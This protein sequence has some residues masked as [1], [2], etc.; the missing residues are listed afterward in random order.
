MGVD[1]LVKTRDPA[2]VGALEALYADMP[3][4]LQWVVPRAL[5]RTN[6][7]EAVEA[8]GRMYQASQDEGSRRWLLQYLARSEG[9]EANRTLWSILERATEPSQRAEAW[10]ALASRPENADLALAELRSP[11]LESSIRRTII[12]SLRGS[13]DAETQELLWGV[14]GTAT[15]VVDRDLALARLSGY[16]DS[17]AANAML[18]H[19]LSGAEVSGYLRSSL[20][21]V[22]ED[23]LRSRQR[24]LAIVAADAARPLKQ[25]TEAAEVLARVDR[26]QAVSALLA[27]FDRLGEDER[28]GVVSSLSSRSL[29][30]EPSRAALERIVGADPSERVREVARRS[31]ER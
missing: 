12:Q 11:A 24:D 19:F 22:E 13:S 17:Q 16:G 26:V 1:A 25:R 7:P 21:R 3:D 15:T 9:P 29:E 4:N 23:V 8:L 6:S 31:L 5:M 18:D 30:G 10:S 2:A 28:V 20:R 27:G 14:Y